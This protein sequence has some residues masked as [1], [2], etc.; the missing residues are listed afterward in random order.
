VA[1][2]GA[3]MSIISLGED[4]VTSTIAY[5]GY[6]FTDLKTV[7]YLV[8]GLPLGVWVINVVIGLFGRLRKRTA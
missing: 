6:F 1:F 2:G 8:I 5:V 7:L 4:F 3:S